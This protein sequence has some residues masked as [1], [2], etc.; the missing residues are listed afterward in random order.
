MINECN[1]RHN[2]VVDQKSDPKMK[3]NT[4]STTNVFVKFIVMN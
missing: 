1:Y 3:E 2:L 4:K